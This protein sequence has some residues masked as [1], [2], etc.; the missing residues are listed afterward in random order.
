MKN[1]KRFL[2]LF[3]LSL[4][5]LFIPA[6]LFANQ[7]EEDS[8]K[9]ITAYRINGGVKIDGVLD[10]DCWSK[11]EKSGGF[12]QADPHDGEPATES[13]YV[14][15]CY[16]NQALYVAVTCMENEPDKILKT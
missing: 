14:Q 4:L 6:N 7:V 1:R 3:S 8:V 9:S 13:T 2:S 5:L 10:E 16:D 12:V 11:E 15:V